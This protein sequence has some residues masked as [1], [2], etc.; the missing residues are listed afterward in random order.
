MGERLF[1]ENNILI[2]YVFLPCYV[3]GFSPLSGSLTYTASRLNNRDTLRN[4]SAY[5]HSNSAVNF[6]IQGNGPSYSHKFRTG[7]TV[8]VSVDRE[9]TWDFAPSTKHDYDDMPEVGKLVRV[10]YT[11]VAHKY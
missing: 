10:L 11:V 8:A 2:G 6:A 1:L 4:L 9:I 7:P 5:E 3:R